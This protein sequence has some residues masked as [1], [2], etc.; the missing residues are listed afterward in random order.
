METDNRFLG[1]M[2]AGLKQKLASVRLLAM[3]VDGVLTDGTLG[4]DSA[5][6]EQKRFHVADGLG[7]VVIQQVGVKVAWISGRK[8]ASVERRAAELGTIC[9]LQHVKYK[10]IAL[11]ELASELKV[12]EEEIAYIGDDWNDLPAFSVAG[13]GIAVANAAFDVKQVAHYV[14]QTLGGHGAV[15]EVCELLLE[16]K[17]I[18]VEGLSLYLDSLR[19]PVSE[20]SCS[21]GQ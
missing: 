14:T 18:R 2:E 12:R 10:S 4:Y 11:Q 9:L 5:G 6:S 21:A 1:A 15:R 3:D 20:V 13:V 19:K 17:E 16:A 7:L 8:S